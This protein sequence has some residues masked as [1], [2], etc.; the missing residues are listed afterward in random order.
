MKIY[1]FPL[2]PRTF[3]VLVTANHLG[4]DYALEIV[5]LQKGEQLQSKITALHPDHRV[6]ILEDDGY[7]LWESNAILQYL[8]AKRPQS[9]LLPMHDI[10]PGL[11][12]VRWQFWD[13]AHWDP[14]CAIFIFEYVVKALIG[15][16]EPDTAEI[17]RGTKLFTR[18]ADLLEH[19]LGKHRFVAG[20]RLTLADFAIGSS[21]II[22]EQARYPLDAYPAIRRWHSELAALP[23]W[24]QTLAAQ[25]PAASAA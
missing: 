22:A 12:V 9:E 3:K 8:A 21:M 25:Q 17:A 4:L 7:V 11:D 6:P 2:S 19:E 5:D 16:G 10:K 18:C 23:A 1:G 15:A 13:G 14:A 20:D 24:Q